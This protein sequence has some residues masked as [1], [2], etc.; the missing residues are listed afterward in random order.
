MSPRQKSDQ[1]GVAHLL[2]IVLALVVVAA[3]GFTAWKVSNNKSSNSS[4]GS[5]SKTA[6]VNNTTVADACDKA[7]NDSNLCKFASH[8]NP[9]APYKAVDTSTTTEGNGTLTILSDGKGNSSV[10]SSA[11]GVDTSFVS[12]GGAT[13][14]QDAT[15]GTWIK[16]SSGSGS[17]ST[18]NPADSFKLSA[19]DITAGGTIGYKN[20]GTEACGSST[21]FKYQIVDT[22][23]PGATEYVWFSN[24]DYQLHE[25]Y[26]KNDN[27][28]NDMTITYQ[29]VTIN[30]P[31]PVQDYSVP[32]Q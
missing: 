6:A 10:T 21:C 3:I 20:L 16:Y 27:G 12:L 29:N 13:Y 19:R 1:R 15:S 22:T 24:D 23:Q 11:N 31:S 5:T 25:F 7:I 9:N 32:T 17:P 18:N 2:F 26:V 4:S 14:V 30:A 8:Y 28:T